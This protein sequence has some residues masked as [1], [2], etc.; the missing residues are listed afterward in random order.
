MGEKK[1]RKREK[2]YFFSLSLC[3]YSLVF[4]TLRAQRG[5]PRAPRYL[6]TGKDAIKTRVLLFRRA[7][8]VLGRR[9]RPR[10][11]G[12]PVTPTR[13]CGTWP[14]GSAGLGAGRGG[15]FFCCQ[16]EIP[17]FLLEW[18]PSGL[19]LANQTQLSK[20]SSS[21]RFKPDPCSCWGVPPV[22]VLPQLGAGSG[23]GAG[24]TG[25]GRRAGAGWGSDAVGVAAPAP[26]IE[27]RR[28]R[29]GPRR[30]WRV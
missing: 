9:G 25:L 12:V 18:R 30:A 8:S 21:Y 10:A 26:R 17:E 4:Q 23:A 29:L 19:Q 16:P 15:C 13:V 27:A 5:A 3:L 22:Q 14:R 28:T 1:R 2:Q 6:L 24:R 7:K 11:R 20:D